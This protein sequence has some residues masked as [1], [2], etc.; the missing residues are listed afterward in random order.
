[1]YL[2]RSIISIWLFSYY[3]LCFTY[4]PLNWITIIN[5]DLII[6]IIP[7]KLIDYLHKTPL[8]LVLLLIPSPSGDDDGETC[9]FLAHGL[10]VFLRLASWFSPRSSIQFRLQLKQESE[11]SGRTTS[12]KLGKGCELNF[13]GR[14]DGAAGYT[15]LP[16]P[17][18]SQEILDSRTLP[19]SRQ[20]LNCGRASNEFFCKHLAAY[21]WFD[22]LLQRWFAVSVDGSG[23]IDAGAAFGFV[24]C[25]RVETPISSSR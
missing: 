11:V 5:H 22:L 1:M 15:A 3:P 24:A 17:P 14:R 13:G 19:R 7:L 10:Q 25:L 4:N 9:L 18:I 8:V 2:P 6:C 16:S 21:T 23:G 12:R 20:R